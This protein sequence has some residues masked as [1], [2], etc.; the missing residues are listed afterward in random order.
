MRNPEMGHTDQTAWLGMQDSNSEMWTQIIA[1]KD[2]TDLRESSRILA[3][4][5][6]RL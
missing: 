6:T 2:R 3:L 5:T 1:L 4:E